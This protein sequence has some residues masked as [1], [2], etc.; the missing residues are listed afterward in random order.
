[1]GARARARARAREPIGHGTSKLSELA[2]YIRA[3]ARE[4]KTEIGKWKSETQS[5]MAPIRHG[6]NHLCRTHVPPNAV[7]FSSIIYI[8]IYI[9]IYY[10]GGYR[11][12]L[13]GL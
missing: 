10:R 5:G 2:S 8:Y 1:M 6:K 9:Y 12:G 3:R 7:A 11:G 4:W 13:R